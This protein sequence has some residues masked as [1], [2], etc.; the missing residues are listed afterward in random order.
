MTSPDS[1]F[2]LPVDERRELLEHDVTLNGKRATIGG[3]MNDFAIVRQLP[4]GLSAEFAWW[5]I[6]H[7]INNSKGEFTA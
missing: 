1:R 6:K 7:V 4:D 3:V 5:T 2:F